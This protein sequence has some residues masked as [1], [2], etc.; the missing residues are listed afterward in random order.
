MLHRLRRLLRLCYPPAALI[1]TYRPGKFCTKIAPVRRPRPSPRGEG[2]DGLHYGLVS[3]RFSGR[4]P[5]SES[6][7]YFFTLGRIFSMASR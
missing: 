1:M 2:N 5:C 7:I 6:T 4:R 3:R